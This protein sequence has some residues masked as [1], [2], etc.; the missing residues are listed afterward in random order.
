[1]F[2]LT[3]FISAIVNLAEAEGRRA[4]QGVG[5]LLMA[6]M[7]LAFCLALLVAALAFTV[8]GE[9]VWLSPHVGEAGASFITAG[10]VLLVALIL[11]FV[12][13]SQTR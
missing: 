11:I 10:S 6:A 7:L 3:E 13:R 12:A 2:I 4:K 5:Q 9:Y 8:W 1:M